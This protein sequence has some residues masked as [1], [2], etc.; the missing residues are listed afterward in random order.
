[1]G[2]SQRFGG[3]SETARRPDTAEDTAE[4]LDYE[5]MARVVTGL[6]GV[7]DDLAG[8]AEPADVEVDE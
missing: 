1:M 2:W 5:R 8:S 6:E 4:K 3:L 7:V